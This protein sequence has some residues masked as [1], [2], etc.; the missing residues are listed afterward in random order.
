VEE[1]M[2]PRTQ[3]AKIEEENEDEEEKEAV[4]VNNANNI[5]LNTE[6]EED[7]IN[8]HLCMVNLL[9][10]VDFLNATFPEPIPVWMGPI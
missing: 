5:M 10:V 2:I 9:R 3:L 1:E 7:I 8:R 4:P 6:I